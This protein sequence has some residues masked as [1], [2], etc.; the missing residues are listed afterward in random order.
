MQQPYISS[1]TH[2]VGA[3]WP[4]FL[5]ASICALISSAGL[6]LQS[7]MPDTFKGKQELP[8]HPS[9]LSST[10]AGLFHE[11]IYIF[12]CLG[13]GMDKIHINGLAT[14][15]PKYMEHQFRLSPSWSVL[16]VGMIII[17]AAGGGTLFG[18]WLIRHLNLRQ[19]GILLWILFSQLISVPF[20]FSLL[21]SCP[22]PQYMSHVE[23]DQMCSGGCNCPNILDNPVCASEGIMYL[24]PCV[25]NCSLAEETKCLSDC[26]YII[27]VFILQVFSLFLTFSAIMPSLVASMR[28][29]SGE[30]RPLALGLREVITKILG[31]IPGPI[32]F[33]F[34]IDFSCSHWE[35]DCGEYPNVKIV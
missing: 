8:D 12:I 19:K 23:K 26:N 18:G 1:T 14:F 13:A 7:K 28:S 32:L 4:G 20:I 11:P 10:I 33:G 15:L 17:P 30:K 25:T 16:V 9:N 6:F 31:Y 27:P 3:W 21:L 24:Y 22:E 34:L 5:L 29:I 35:P 2:W